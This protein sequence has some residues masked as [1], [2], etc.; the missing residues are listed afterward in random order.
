MLQELNDS[1]KWLFLAFSI[2]AGVII[3][4]SALNI[5]NVQSTAVLERFKEI[6]IL[7]SIG[8]SKRDI[9]KI[10]LM[11]AAVLGF[12][13]GILG[14]LLGLGVNKLT[15]VILLYYFPDVSFKPISLF[16]TSWWLILGA[17]AFSIVISVISG[18][19]PASKAAKID[20]IEAL[21]YE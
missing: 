4:V 3:F 18:Y 15:D 14:I 7:R 13:G 21:R 17:F 20:P 8:A 9:R 12:L 1:I 10:F 2:V 5:L 19:Y 11:E 6:G 16:Y